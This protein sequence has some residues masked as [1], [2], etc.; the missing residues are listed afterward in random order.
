MAIED[1]WWREEAAAPPAALRAALAAAEAA[2]RLGAAARA[3][4]YRTPLARPRRAAVPVISVGNLVVGGAGKTPVALEVARRLLAAGRRVAILSRGYGGRGARS[5]LVSAGGRVRLGAAE[6]G[7]EPFLLAQRL[8][9]ALVLC[10][11]RRAALAQEAAA[12]G[13][14]A[15]VLDDGFQHRGLARDL[16]IVVIDAADPAGNGRL[17]P[18][19]PNREP[20]A[21]LGRA[22]LAWLSRV[23]QAAQ[24]DPAALAALRRRVEAATG[25]PPVA[26]RYAVSA[27]LSGDRARSLGTDALA[28]RRALLLCGLARPEGFRRT[29]AGLGAVVAAERVFRDHHPFTSRDVEE[30]FR[31]AAAAGCEV[32]ATTEKDAVRL[33]PGLAADPRWRVVQVT[34]ELAEGAAALDA[35]L[36]AVLAP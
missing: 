32:V 34:A 24:A 22:H 4:L 27:V 36:G 2:Y 23:D 17:L 35:L 3:A 5:R 9:G 12:A 30:A 33:P 14:E 20:F 8:P 10:G 28:G 29:L 16:D 26:S 6:A 31:A 15:L 13:A 21:A 25:R 19:G 7:D 1:I 11:P 18:R